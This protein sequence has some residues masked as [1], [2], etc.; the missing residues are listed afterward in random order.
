MARN[1][2]QNSEAI[3]IRFMVSNAGN[4]DDT[5]CRTFKLFEDCNDLVRLLRHHPVD[6]DVANQGL[7]CFYA[8]LTPTLDTCIVLNAGKAI[9]S[10]VVCK[11]QYPV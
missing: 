7:I 6:M 1:L 9:T 10:L 4:W 3:R 8:H 2:L 5:S 11:N